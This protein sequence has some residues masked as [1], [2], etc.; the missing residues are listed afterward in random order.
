MSKKQDSSKIEDALERLKETAKLNKRILELEKENQGLQQTIELLH[1]KIDEM[2][3]RPKLLDKYELSAEEVIASTQL[4]KLKQKAMYQDLTLEEIKKF[5][6]LVKN[7]RLANGDSTENASYKM[8]LPVSQMDDAKLL[9]VA[10][11]VSDER[12]E[13]DSEND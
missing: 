3:G 8:I 1:K 12:K 9:E 11:T 13:D 5:D 4:E 6:L 10:R 7:R 2:E